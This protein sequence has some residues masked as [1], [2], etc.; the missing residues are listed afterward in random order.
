MKSSQLR[1]NATIHDLC[2]MTTVT[3]WMMIDDEQSALSTRPTIPNLN[4]M[5]TLATHTVGVR[6]L[7]LTFSLFRERYF[8]ALYTVVYTVYLVF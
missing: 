8:L 6:V 5:L 3:A 1:M 2:T 7:S 4:R